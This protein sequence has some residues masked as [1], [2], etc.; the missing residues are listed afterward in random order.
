MNNEP[1]QLG[2]FDAAASPAAIL[3][4]TN[5]IAYFIVK[6][7]K[8]I[9]IAFLMLLIAGMGFGGWK[10]SN[11]MTEKFTKLEQQNS[12][13]KNQVDTLQKNISKLETDIK[14]ATKQRE[15]FDNK[16]SEL[17]METDSLRRRIN[18]IGSKLPT[19]TTPEVAQNTLNDLRDDI[20]NRW[21][22]IGSGDAKK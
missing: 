5:P 11:Y 13:Y 21:E 15:E 16:I 6:H 2:L 22:S 8:I 10:Y 3:G 19:G 17:K 1:M 18:G 12:E 14:A 9:L 4:T 20:K 7:W